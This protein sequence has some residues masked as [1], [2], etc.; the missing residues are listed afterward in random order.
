MKY[1]I[2]LIVFTL[3]LGHVNAAD[4][5]ID[6]DE[7]V[8]IALENSEEMKLA[9][10]T[11]DQS[12]LNRQI[13]RTAYLPNFS[14]SLTTMWK[15][16]DT[17]YD[18]MGIA[19]RMKGM[20]M[21][22]INLTQPIFVGG[23]IIAANKLAGIGKNVASEQMRL[24]KINVTSN[25][26]TTYWS[27]VAVL[28]KV[29]MMKSYR[30]LVDTAYNQTKAALDA[31][32]ATRNE[33]LR[34]DARRSQ[35]IYQQEQVNNGAELCRMALCNALGLPLETLI[36]TKDHDIPLDLP[37]DLGQYNLDAR[38]EMQLL[39]SDIA[40]KEQQVKITRADFLPSLGLQA[41]WSMFSNLKFDMMET[42]PDGS[43][44]PTSR[45]IKSDGWSIMLSLQVPIFHWGEGYKKVKH[46]KIDVD[47][48][49]LRLDERTRQ[50]DLQ[51]QQAVANVK[52][53][54]EL[55]SAAQTAV[56]Q[57]QA[58]LDSTSEAYYLG[59]DK[60]ADLLDAQAQWQTAR[61]SLIEAQTQLRVNIVDYLAA[62]AQL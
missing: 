49:R 42:M 35:V 31:G 24:T 32:M 6:V 13:A 40:A 15:L 30:A 18:E 28:A 21:A 12:N 33:L 62:T 60:I 45:N 26:M 36:V 58:A 52:T 47:N 16:P 1:I 34:I 51:V 11:V 20:Y 38:P 3:S 25:A 43:Y 41:G 9:K 27:Y 29:E 55:V 8:A 56:K 48:A 19:L 23:K 2:P 10:N 22:G 57:A 17:K 4:M 50:L 61:A 44:V 7:A 5:I 54:L 59:M 37:A 14:G 46:A 53:G 39:L